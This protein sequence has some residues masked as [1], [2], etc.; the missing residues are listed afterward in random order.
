MRPRVPSLRL[1]PD[2]P[3]P[4]EPD[5]ADAPRLA[6]AVPPKLLAATRGVPALWSGLLAALTAGPALGDAPLVEAT[7]GCLDF[8]RPDSRPCVRGCGRRTAA[9]KEV[10][11]RCIRDE[12]DA[13]KEGAA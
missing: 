4:R 8:G 7:R 10:C 6:A 5:H 13:A 1:G 9:A 3:R 11:W 12:A 2:S